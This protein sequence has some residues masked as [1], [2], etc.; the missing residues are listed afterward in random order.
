MHIEF[1]R[2]IH[3]VDDTQ[4][5]ALLNDDYP[6]ARH[7]FLA[8]LEDSQAVDGDSGWHSRHL[9]VREGDTLIAA[10][11]GYLKDHSYGEY[12]FDWA[13]ADAYQRYGQ[14]YYPKWLGAIPFTPCRGPRLLGRDDAST[15]AAIHH[16]L[17]EYC[18][19]KALSSWHLL[20]PE[21]AISNRFT[22]LG[23]V[24]RLGCQFHWFNQNY[25][26]FDDFVAS[27]ASRKRKNVL[28]ERR[29]VGEQG[30]S[31][32]TLTGAELQPEHWSF[33]H[34]L[35]QRTYLKRSGHG[36]YLNEAFFQAL[37]ANLAEHCVMV[38]AQLGH[39]TVAA[40]LYLSDQ[41][42]LY[43]R[44]WGCLAEFDNLHFETCYYQGIDYAIAQGLTR[45]DGGAQG[46]H[47]LARG[48]E[49]VLTYSNHHLSDP[50]FAAAVADFVVEE[51]AM[52]RGYYQDAQAHLPYAQTKAGTKTNHKD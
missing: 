17:T 31:F 1:I 24:Q 18:Q 13:W 52:T 20:F 44:Y 22:E 10:L 46:E 11:P 45:F 48:F 3:T 9:I 42:T 33:F 34:Q 36:G 28:K 19:R 21:H 6:F 4:W 30:F 32:T 35:Y 39:Q 16:A 5:N 51:G 37:G 14:R 23:S 8:A 50:R 12:V 43:G 25:R 29:R 26:S 41:H 7:E 40:A 2:S 38:L 15:I 27:F 49:P 47:K